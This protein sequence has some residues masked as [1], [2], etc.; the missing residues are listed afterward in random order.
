MDDNKFFGNNVLVDDEWGD[1]DYENL[2]T[3]TKWRFDE[4]TGK[5]HMLFKDGPVPRL[6]CASAKI[7][8]TTEFYRIAV[9]ASS[10]E[11]LLWYSNQSD[12]LNVTLKRATRN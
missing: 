12:K 7:S 8:K 4:E 1:V 11:V 5:L 6:L 9:L 10:Q 2:E 3:P